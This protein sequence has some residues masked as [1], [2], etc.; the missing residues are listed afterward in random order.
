M[1]EKHI[2][3]MYCPF[4]REVLA[5]GLQGRYDYLNA[6]ATAY[7]CM[8]LGQTFEGNHADP[9]EYDEQRAFA[10]IESFMETLNL[11]QIYEFSR[12]NR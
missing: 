9:R 12:E 6:V 3:G 1:T 11:R 4:S 2:F 5:Q 7:P 10:R 8:H